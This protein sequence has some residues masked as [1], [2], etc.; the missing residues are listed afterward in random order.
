MS[1]NPFFDMLNDLSYGK[2]MILNDENE[3]TYSPYVINNMYSRFAD[4]V[5]YAEEMNCRPNIPKR[6]HYLFMMHS[7]RKRKRFGKM[8]K[9]VRHPDFD[10]VQE[11]YKYSEARTQEVL[12]ILTEAQ[13]Q[14]IVALCYKGGRK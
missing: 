9:A 5:I 10:T 1:N 4:S 8:P 12:S 14:E 2:Q 6:M 11:Y 3:G 7:M 13:I